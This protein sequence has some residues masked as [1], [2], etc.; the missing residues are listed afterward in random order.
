MAGQGIENSAAASGAGLSQT[1]ERAIVEALARVA[2][3]DAAP[4]EGPLF[5]PMA[6]AYYDPRRGTPSGSKSDE[7]LGFGVDAAAAVVLV[8]PVALE[9]AKN[10]LGYVVGEL[11]TAFKDEA[12]PMIQA[13]VKR[14]LRRGPKPEDDKAAAELARRARSRARGGTATDAGSTRR[15]S[16]S[17]P[18]DRRA[19]GP[20]RAQ[21]VGA[22]RCDRGGDGSLGGSAAHATRGCSDAAQPVR[23][24][25]RHDLPVPAVHRRDHRGQP[26]RLRLAV[27]AVRRPQ[28]RGGGP[29]PVPARNECCR[30]PATHRRTAVNVPGVHGRRERSSTNG[31][32]GGRGCLALRRCRGIRRRSRQVAPPVPSIARS[33]RARAVGPDQ[34]PE[35]RGRHDLAAR[36]SVAAGRHAGAWTRLRAA[37]ASRARVHRGSR[38]ACG[39]RP[40]RIPIHRPPRA[41][42]YSKSRCRPRLLRDRHLASAGGRGDHPVRRHPAGRVAFRSGDCGQLRVAVAGTG[43]ARVSGARRH[44]PRARARRR[45]SSIHARAGDPACPGRRCGPGA[46]DVVDCA[47]P[48]V[49]PA[50]FVPGRGGDESRGTPPTASAWRSSTT[51][52][53]SFVSG[54]STPWASAS[55][56]RWRTRRSPPS[57]GTSGSVRSRRG[58]CRRLRSVRWSA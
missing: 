17:G 13:L 52:P 29:V 36:A 45:C 2:V 11:Q 21:G 12:K 58:D 28:R 47:L 23:V 10:V 56:G 50:G 38:A 3:D 27:L 32:R 25:V 31:G 43:T 37:W 7:M 39:P 54:C 18:V 44:P 19:D 53:R 20:S 46:G 15:A 35:R 26:A 4:E 55:S 22:G 5:G 40:A 48:K 1:D 42:A 9:V 41:R 14:V 57:W 34:R 33:R 6:D 8:T 49:V 30:R 24:S 16:Q 51:P